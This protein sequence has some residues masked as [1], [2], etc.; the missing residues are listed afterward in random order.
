[1]AVPAHDKRDKD[2]AEKFNLP[3]IPVILKESKKSMSY[4]MGVDEAAIES[5]G[6]EILRKT[7][8]G[9]FEVEIP[10]DQL[11]KYKELIRKNME[12]HFW[13]EF[14]T[15]DGFY[16][17]FKH[18]DGR[19]EE[20]FL[21]EKTNDLIDRYGATFNDKEPG[22]EPGNVY[23]WIAENSFYSKLLIHSDQGVLINSGKFNGKLSSDV[24]NEIVQ[25][26]GGQKKTK[27]KL[28][29]WVFSRQ[30]YWGEPIPVVSCAICGLVPVPEKDLPVK[31]PNVK[32]YKPT[33][34]GESPLAMIENWVKVRCPKCKGWAKRETDTMPNWAGSSWYYL[35][36]IDAKNKKVF[37]DKNKLKTWLP[38]DWYNGG[39]EHVTLHLLYSRFWHKFLFDQKLVP[40]KEPYKKRT[41]HGFVLAP[42]GQKMSKSKGN[43]I[44]PDSI[45]KLLGADTL[46]VY[47]MFMGPFAD[48]ISWNTDS[49]AGSR[50]FIERV[51]RCIEKISDDKNNKNDELDRLVNNTVKKVSDDYEGMKFN[52]AVS[53]MM[54]LVNE[55]DKAVSIPKSYFET[56]LILL[57]P[58]APHVTEELWE[59][60]GNKKSIHLSAW[61]K[62]K[63][64]HKNNSKI[65]IVIQVNSKVRDT[66]ELTMNISDDKLKSLALQRENV[67]KWVGSSKIKKIFVVKNRLINIVI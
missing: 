5:I 30:R 37:A 7:D 65:K 62:Y 47:E 28:R 52:T 43:V 45:V 55:F 44:N 20:M 46:R 18:K 3:I 26:V 67:R 34:T 32:N 35:R 41:A 33:D 40:T 64:E 66:M 48:A 53:A 25:F 27:Y 36:Y 19:I 17:I 31:L 22:K 8:D 16:F 14:S 57:A 54:I 2:F 58:L 38:V 63:L 24:V 10:Y 49:V 11:D 4:V 50:R 12:P 6:V 60:L 42:D 59:R 13:N 1:M 21:N 61:P 39:M 51:W 56:F 15:R 9:Y 29:D 23:S